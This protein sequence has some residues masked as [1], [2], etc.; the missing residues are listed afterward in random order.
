MS[1]ASSPAAAMAPATVCM[2][3]S[4]R[5][6]PGQAPAGTADR[7]SDGGDDDGVGGIAHDGP[8]QARTKTGIVNSSEIGSNLTLSA[9]PTRQLVEGAVDHVG[10]HA[11]PLGQVDDGGHVGDAVPEGRLVVVVDHRPG[12]ERGL[13]AGLVP[14]H[15]LAPALRAEGTRVV[16][17]GAAVEAVLDEQALLPGGLPELDGVALGRREVETDR[18]HGASSLGRATGGPRPWHANSMVTPGIDPRE[19]RRPCCNEPD[20]GV[21]F[22]PTS[23]LG[24][25]VSMRMD[26][27]SATRQIPRWLSVCT[28]AGDV[29]GPTRRLRCAFEATPRLSRAASG[30]PEH[31]HEI[32]AAQPRPWLSESWRGVGAVSQHERT[33][34]GRQMAGKAAKRATGGDVGTNGAPRLR[35]GRW[36][37]SP[38]RRESKTRSKR[39]CH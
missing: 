35:A 34:G 27:K 7:G 18:G 25:S 5:L 36:P 10:H 8:P 15:P 39:W 16:R 17:V 33:I 23:L 21:N 29:H 32:V 28:D 24:G 19:S 1:P 37:D 14:L 3:M 13:P 2:P 4:W 31:V 12:V 38:R 11:G 20:T 6:R 9:M 22:A 26:V 30:S